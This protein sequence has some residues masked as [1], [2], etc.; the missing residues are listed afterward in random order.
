MTERVRSK[1]SPHG[2]AAREGA[3]SGTSPFSTYQAQQSC[4]RRL[5]QREKDG[6]KGWGQPDADGEVH[7]RQL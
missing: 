1:D 6:G 2:R 3:G 4:S 7:R 5:G